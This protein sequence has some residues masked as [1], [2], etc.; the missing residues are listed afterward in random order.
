MSV[1][2]SRSDIMQVALWYNLAAS[3]HI[4]HRIELGAVNVTTV[5]LL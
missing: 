4:S 2:S 1:R 5:G 3:R